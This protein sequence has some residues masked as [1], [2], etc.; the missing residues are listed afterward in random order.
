MCTSL[1]F[2]Q[3][4]K[5]AFDRAQKHRQTHANT[6]KH[7][8]LPPPYSTPPD[9][10]KRCTPN[11]AAPIKTLASLRPSL[12]W[13]SLGCRPGPARKCASALKWT[14][15][16]TQHCKGNPILPSVRP[17]VLVLVGEGESRAAEEKGGWTYERRGKG[18]RGG[19]RK[20]GRE[21]ERE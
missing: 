1:P 13:V 2:N 7:T 8:H 19:V 3:A 18:I 6:H 4:G 10:Q 5:Q 12:H 16:I 15:A 20:G 9:K 17:L 21:R 14:Q 11:P